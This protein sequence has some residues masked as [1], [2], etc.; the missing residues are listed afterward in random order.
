MEAEQNQN[1]SSDKDFKS[2]F[3][4]T[5]SHQGKYKNILYQAW[6]A[7]DYPLRSSGFDNWR[8]ASEVKKTSDHME[9]IFCDIAMMPDYEAREKTKKLNKQQKANR[10]K[11]SRAR[12]LE[13]DRK[14]LVE[15]ELQLY[16]ARM[17]EAEE[18]ACKE[19][20]LHQEMLREKIQVFHSRRKE[21]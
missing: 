17:K 5:S 6:P 14:Q 12:V 16:R 19:E 3:L 7:I 8:H 13:E 18:N 9:N 10:L 4:K 2:N 15:R 1:K 20:K 21:N 11:Q